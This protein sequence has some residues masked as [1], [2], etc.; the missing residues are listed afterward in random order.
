[1]ELFVL[2]LNHKSAALPV[3]EKFA[4]RED[5]IDE[6]LRESAQLPNVEEVLALSTCNRVEIYG[7]SRHPQ[8]AQVQ[9]ANFLTEFQMASPLDFQQHAYFHQGEG[10]IRHGFRVAAGLDSMIVGEPQILGQVKDA[11]RQAGESGTAGRILHKFFQHVF[12][13]AKKVRT[14]TGIASSPVSVSYAAVTLARQ[15]FGEL[16][17]RKALILGAGKMSNLAIKHIKNSGVKNFFIANRTAERAEELARQFNGQAIPFENFPKWLC[18]VDLVLTSTNAPEY[19]IDA[20]MVSEAMKPRKN[21]P[22]FF[23]DIAVP[24]DVSPEVNHLP[25]VFL[26][27]VDDLGA[28]VEANRGE[29]L[30][31]AAQAEI[32]LEGEVGEFSKTLRK[33]EIVSAL[34]SRSPSPEGERRDAPAL[35]RKIFRLDEI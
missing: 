3:R 9:L 18:D 15:I 33:M 10:A 7:A 17:G 35:V 13:T 19:L 26:Y 27:D 1:M 4:I 23:I 6:F 5:R 14:E 16:K 20:K 25:N 21:H 28:V 12:F 29:R 32:L 30:K 24:R 34:S 2:G 31:E 22:M 11:Y 8:Q